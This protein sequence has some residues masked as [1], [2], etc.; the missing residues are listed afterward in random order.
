MLFTKNISIFKTAT[1]KTAQFTV[2]KGR[3]MPKN[4]YSG[5]LIFLITISTNCTKVAIT[6]IKEMVRRYVRLKGIS[7]NL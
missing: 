5:G 7:K 3:Y 2:I 6:K 4:L 1:P